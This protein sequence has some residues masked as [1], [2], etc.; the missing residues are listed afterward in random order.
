[1][2]VLSMPRLSLGSVREDTSGEGCP[3]LFYID[4]NCCN[5]D[6]LC[7]LSPIGDGENAPR[8]R[9]SARRLRQR[10]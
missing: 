10:N 5:E 7:Y 9:R 8:I 1:M 6:L 3:L 2:G 4:L